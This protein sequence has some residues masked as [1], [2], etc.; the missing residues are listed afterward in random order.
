MSKNS[1]VLV[2][3]V[4]AALYLGTGAAA[5]DKAKAAPAMT[6]VAPDIAAGK[7]VFD[8]WCQGCHAPIT[9]AGGPF[10][11][12]PAGTNRLQQRYQG[13]LPAGLEDRTDL[14]P[15]L[16]RVAVRQGLPIMPPLRKTEVTDGDL[17]AVIAYL[18]QKKRK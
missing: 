13:A 16:I 10:G 3:C 17:D 9:G 7:R 2:T 8:Q 12:P 18:T 4:A 6:K 14:K 1:W 15:E 5:A 11:F